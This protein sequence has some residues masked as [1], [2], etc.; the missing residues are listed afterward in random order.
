MARNGTPEKALNA[1]QL[2]EITRRI[3]GGGPE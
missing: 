3:W 1:G 2:A